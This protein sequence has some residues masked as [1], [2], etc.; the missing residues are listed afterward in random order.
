[1][2]ENCGMPASAIVG[3]SG[4]SVLLFG[5]VVT[6]ARSLPSRMCVIDVPEEQN[7]NCTRPATR[8]VIACGSP[9]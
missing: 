8:S 9:L 1:M 3:T 2:I 6:S 5:S 4:S 7:M